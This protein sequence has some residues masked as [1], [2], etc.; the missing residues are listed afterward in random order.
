MADENRILSAPP[1]GT[2]DNMYEIAGAIDPREVG[3]E[4]LNAG[5]LTDEE[6]MMA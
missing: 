2:G 6:F 4:A 5:A 1:G 3:V